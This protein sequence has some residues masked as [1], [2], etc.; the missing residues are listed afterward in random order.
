VDHGRIPEAHVLSP[1]RRELRK[2]LSIR[3]A[4][5]ETRS[6]YVVTIRGLAR[7]EGTA[8]PSCSTHNF[9]DRLQAT[10]LDG[11]IRALI[12]PLVAALE[13][14]EQQLAHVDDELEQVAKTDPLIR[15]CAT[16]PG[17]GLIVAAT[18][19][20]VIDDPKRFKSAH[21]VSAYLGLR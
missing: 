14:I 6:Q 20:S 17:V 2:Q 4:L 9:L 8:L 12:A 15:L 1:A 18:F 19:L 16:V 10:E 11:K 5:V 21:A 7:A 13:A 3:Q